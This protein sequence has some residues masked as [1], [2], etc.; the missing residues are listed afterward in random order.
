MGESL[1]DGHPAGAFFERRFERL[2]ATVADAILDP[3]HRDGPS[4]SR[5]EA[6]TRATLYIA[7]SDGL[8]SQ[9]LANPDLDMT[10]SFAALR[11]LMAGRRAGPTP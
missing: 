6:L 7:V 10:S 3:S 4:L 8:Q 5:E 11:E 2:R 9:W 1:T